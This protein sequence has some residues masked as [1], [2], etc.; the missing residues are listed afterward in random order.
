MK[1]ICSIIFMVMVLSTKVVA[2]I[3][4]SY[5]YSVKKYPEIT[6]LL[7]QDSFEGEF[8]LVNIH[9]R[10]DGIISFGKSN[11]TELLLVNYI[12]ANNV[13]TNHFSLF[14][15]LRS[16]AYLLSDIDIPYLFDIEHEGNK[17]SLHK[18]STSVIDNELVVSYNFVCKLPSSFIQ[19]GDCSNHELFKAALNYKYLDSQLKLI[20]TKIEKI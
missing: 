17:Y 18:Q 9:M 6:K 15:E 4:G 11:D 14:I 3:E 16:G 12:S 7:N 2:D 5:D 13:A 1:F 20:S 19:V 8:S 10:N